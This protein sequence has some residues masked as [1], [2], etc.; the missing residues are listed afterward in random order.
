MSGFAHDLRTV[1]SGEPA[2]AAACLRWPVAGAALHGLALGASS[3]EPLLALYS[4][5]KVPLLLGCSCLVTLPNFYVLHAVLGLAADFGAACRGLLAAQA[6]LALALGAFAPLVAM[7]FASTAN[8]YLLTVVDGALF[9]V[10][11]VAGQVVLRRHY[12]RLL[13]RDRRHRITLASWLVLY[14]FFAIQL[15]WVLRPFLGTPGY[16]VQ[17]LRDEALQQNAYVVVFEHLGRMFR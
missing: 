13:A 9:A 17:F 16:P 5:V 1:L 3:G 14:V 10:A 8:G 12:A 4:A 6:A 7:T 15:A 11:A 2:P